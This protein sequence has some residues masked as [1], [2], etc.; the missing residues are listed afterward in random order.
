MINCMSNLGCV[1]IV[2][3]NKAV[4]MKKPCMYVCMYVFR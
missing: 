3:V 4:R 2:G 1:Y